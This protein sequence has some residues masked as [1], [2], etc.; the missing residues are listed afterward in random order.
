MVGFSWKRWREHA[1][2]CGISAPGWNR[3]F[4]AEHTVAEN[5]A[6][7][8]T[9]GLW[10]LNSRWLSGKKLLTLDRTRFPVLFSPSVQPRAICI[11][12]IGLHLPSRAA[13]GVADGCAAT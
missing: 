5:D 4:T 11:K 6:R 7:K 13:A 3:R 12:A 1:T 9:S 10:A 8:S 2:C